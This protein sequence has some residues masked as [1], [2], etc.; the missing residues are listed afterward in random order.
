[1]TQ[2][3]R[4]IGNECRT[5][6]CQCQSELSRQFATI[7]DRLADGFFTLDSSWRF[8]YINPA[9]HK[10]FDS[11]SELLGKAI[12]VVYPEARETIFETEF[13]RVMETSAIAEFEAFYP[14]L[15]IWLRVNAFPFNEGVAVSFADVTEARQ[16]RRRLDNLDRQL[17]QSARVAIEVESFANAVVHDLRTPLSAILG[18]SHALSEYA[19]NELAPRSSDY[20]RRIESAARQMN[21]ATVAVKDFCWLAG[22]PVKRNLLDL[23]LIARDCVSSLRE[24]EIGRHVT[25]SIAPCMW[26]DCD[27]HLMKLA[28]EK[29]LANAWKNAV[30][31]SAPSIDI[32]T[33]LG[34]DKEIWYFIRDNGMGLGTITARGVTPPILRLNSDSFAGGGVGLAIVRRIIDKHGGA[35]WAVA[36]P[37]NGA[38]IYFTLPAE[39][40]S[41]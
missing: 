20:L 32:G 3:D 19:V 22:A 30:H 34:P 15:R 39:S 25:C 6:D 7:F 17:R 26:A 29:L 1:M 24:A 31:Q 36:Q 4:L 12:W 14:D 8:T 40:A 11:G 35:L 21:E 37:G 28:L 2:S 38:T 33:E 18:F 13:R 9:A 27:P 16:A 10:A 41:A 5:N 23:S